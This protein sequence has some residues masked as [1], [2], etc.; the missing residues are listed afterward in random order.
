MSQNTCNNT[1]S[2]LL[3]FL[4]ESTFCFVTSPSV[5][6]VLWVCYVH[7]IQ[8][9]EREPD[10]DDLTDKIR[11]PNLNISLGLW[12]KMWDL[13]LKGKEDLNMRTFSWSIRFKMIKEHHVNQVLILLQWNF[14]PATR[15][16]HHFCHELIVTS[17]VWLCLLQEWP[18]LLFM[19]CA[20]TWTSLWS[21]ERSVG[22]E[23]T[24]PLQH[25]NVA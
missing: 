25:A 6:S 8:R 19:V 11:L 1:F 23:V 3:S 21:P 22:R 12:R 20:H 10:P 9:L 7:V 4:Q 18:L 15:P 17:L 5:R 24:F 13:G 2:R 14:Q 16:W